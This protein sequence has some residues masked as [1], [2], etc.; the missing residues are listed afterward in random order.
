VVCK[1]ISKDT[2]NLTVQHKHKIT[3]THKSNPN[4]K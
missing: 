4:T 1:E 2:T 3:Q